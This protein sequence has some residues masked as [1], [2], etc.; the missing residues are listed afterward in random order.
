MADERPL[1]LKSTRSS[2]KKKKT[3]GPVCI[4]HYQ[5]NKTDCTIRQLSESSF[6]KIKEA[7]EVRKIQG[8][9]R[10]RLSDICC[11]ALSEY[12]PHLHG[13]HRWCYKNF[14]NVSRI[15]KRKN[16]SEEEDAS[17]SKKART[18]NPSATRV[19]LPADTCLFCDKNRM[20][21]KQRVERL[22]KCVTRNL[23]K[24]QPKGNKINKPF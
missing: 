14:T 18:A 13:Y 20:T 2:E 1:T 7:V 15:L 17:S 4:I 16:P 9:E 8:N 5:Q 19:L 22:V 3:L 6:K 24:K 21:K 23:S 12:I 11:Q 10:E